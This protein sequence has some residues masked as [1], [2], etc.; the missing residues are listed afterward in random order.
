MEITKI[1]KTILQNDKLEKY[2]ASET[3]LLFALM[4]L[5]QERANEKGQFVATLDEVCKRYGTTCKTHLLKIREALSKKGVIKCS[6]T[7]SKSSIYTF[8][9]SNKFSTIESNKNS[10]TYSNNFS[11]TQGNKIST[12]QG[13]KNSTTDSN[14]FSTIESNKNS[15]S[16]SSTPTT[17]ESKIF[18]AS[19]PFGKIQYHTEV[20]AKNAPIFCQYVMDLFCTKAT[21]KEIQ[22]FCLYWLKEDE[23]T[24]QP[25]HQTKQNFSLSDEFKQFQEKQRSNI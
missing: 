18:E 17:Q 4:G 20:A 14:K 2:S 10:T 6:T 5:Y 3:R 13:N 9:V 12:T 25:L 11:T 23:I 22:K 21:L 8:I 7:Q 19:T 15:T 1:L 24:K 16:S